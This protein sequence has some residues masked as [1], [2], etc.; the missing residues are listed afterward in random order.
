VLLGS[1]LGARVLVVVETRLLRIVFGL[2]ILALGVE[3][4]YKG[5]TGN[6]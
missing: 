2:V 6:L 3:M 1:M 5:I 4:I